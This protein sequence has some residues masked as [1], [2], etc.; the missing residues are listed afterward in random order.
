[1]IATIFALVFLGLPA[2]A[3][4]ESVAPDTS[5]ISALLSD[6][7]F[8][9]IITTPTRGQIVVFERYG[10]QTARRVVGLPFEPIVEADAEFSIRAKSTWQLWSRAEQIVMWMQGAPPDPLPHSVHELDQANIL[11]RLPLS[12]VK[13][14]P[15]LDDSLFFLHADNRPAIDEYEIRTPAQGADSREWGPI[16][17]RTFVGVILLEEEKE[18]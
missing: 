11:L 1:M 5:I 16:H 8:A 14:A 18:Q 6:D 7:P 2:L 12:I 3:Q 9:A 10:R 4:T 13:A 15:V 17:Q